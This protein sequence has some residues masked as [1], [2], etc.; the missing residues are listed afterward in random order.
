MTI[1]AGASVWYGAVLRA[2]LG[3]IVVREGANVQDGSVLRS[4]ETQPCVIGPGATVG[5]LCVVHSALI[6]A[7]A[8]VDN[9][10]IV[11]DGAVVGDRAMVAAG[12]LVTGEV[13]PDTLMMGTPARAK[14]PV[15]G[16]TAESWVRHNPRIYAELAQRH[17]TG[18]REL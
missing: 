16:S 7:G 18:L 15:T 6:G 10:A 9:G 2:D 13:P 11:L 1:E 3:S 8:L 14:G 4:G 5:H 12:P 17:V